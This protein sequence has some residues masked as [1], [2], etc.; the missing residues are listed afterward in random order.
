[1]RPISHALASGIVA[2]GVWYC[3]RDIAPAAACFVAGWL[4]DL[5]H[6]YDYF[7]QHGFETNYN[8]M[9]DAHATGDVR[10]FGAFLHGWEYLLLF[11]LAFLLS[12]H[13][14]VIFYAGVGY[15][16]HLLTDEIFNYRHKRFTYFIVYRLL[17][18]FD[19]PY[20]DY[21]KDT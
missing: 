13:N 1:M 8:R 2:A 11:L 14:R 18:G 3:E 20:F 21:P 12:G 16:L 9:Y 10:G 19:E 7:R 6:F 15:S 5:D 17:R 4:I